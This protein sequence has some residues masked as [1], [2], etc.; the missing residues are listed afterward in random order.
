MRTVII[1]VALLA[2]S[3]AQGKWYHPTATET[4]FRQDLLEC[5]YDASKATAS[6]ASGFQAGWEKGNLQRMCLQTRGYYWR[7]D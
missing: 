7:A 2:S 4:Q 5:E 3:C 6:I 1:G